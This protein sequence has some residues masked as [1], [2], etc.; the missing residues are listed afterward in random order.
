MNKIRAA[1]AAT[2]VGLALS[3]CSVQGQ[4]VYP[5]ADKIQADVEV[6][7]SDARADM[8]KVASDLDAVSLAAGLNDAVLLSKA[9]VSWSQ[10]L[11]AA[12]KWTVTPKG[13]AS[14][15]AR[16]AFD[17]WKL[18]A[19]EC[20]TVGGNYVKAANLLESGTEHLQKSA[21]I[22]NGKATA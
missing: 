13:A 14:V 2:A 8:K 17:D 6:W 7:R 1:L 12:Y 11:S 15:E 19:A 9:C 4:A 5:S 21:D 16:A 20:A 10:D 3:A 22:L 18:A